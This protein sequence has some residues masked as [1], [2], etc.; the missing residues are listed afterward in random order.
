MY[1]GCT[2][3]HIQAQAPRK[4]APGAPC[5]GCGVCCLLEPCP[6]GQLLTRRR[7]GACKALRW[8]EAVPAYRCGALEAPRAVLEQLLPGRLRGLARWLAPGLARLARRWIG[9]QLGCDSALQVQPQPVSP[10]IAP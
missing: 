4:P 9:L 1:Q 5:N 6:L 2:V 7:R 10:T 8:H 3:I